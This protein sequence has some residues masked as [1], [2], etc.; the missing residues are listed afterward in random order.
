[1]KWPYYW[2]YFYCW[3]PWCKYILLFWRTKNYRL[4]ISFRRF[5]SDVKRPI[6]SKDNL[7]TFAALTTLSRS[8]FSSFQLSIFDFTVNSNEWYLQASN[9]FSYSCPI[10]PFSGIFGNFPTHSKF[11][12]IFGHFVWKNRYY[13]PAHY[14]SEYYSPEN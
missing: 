4:R 7:L 10:L 13:N 9:T 12:L 14:Y 3:W 6:L 5:M 8:L 1:M 2:A 11:F